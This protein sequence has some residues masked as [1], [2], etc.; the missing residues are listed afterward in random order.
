MTRI[1]VTILTGFLGSGKTTLLNR[2]LRDPQLKGSVVIVNE[3]GEI[4]LDHELIEASSDSVVLLRNGCLCC[5]VRGDLVE[6]LVDLHRKR[7]KGEISAFDHVVIETSGLAEPTPVTEVLVAAPGV[8]SCFSLA[9]I[10]ATVDA[11]NG[12]V[13]LDAHEQSVKQVALADRIV[14]TKSD[15]LTRP[16]ELRERLGRL[17]PACEVLDARDVDAGALMRF[18][19]GDRQEPAWRSV[20]ASHGERQVGGS[21]PHGEAHGHDARIRRFAIVRDEPW[22][23]DTLTLLL[24]ALATNAGPALLRVKG[25]IH[26]KD[27]PERP[28]VIHGAQELVH[29]LSW[30]DRWPSEDRRT[31]IVFI[32]MDQGAEEIGELV[33]D[34][35][36]L[37]QRTR[38]ARSRGGRQVEF[39][40]DGENR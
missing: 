28:A 40:P 21:G 18:P 37:S 34:I 1:P 38:A 3:F 7:L 4:G 22:D 23:L 10:V 33:E 2:A 27:S 35:E 36:R 13:T 6:T 14:M 19:A 39:S 11:V 30:L 24:E 29:S 25:L 5:S 16:D 17:N 15:L 31:R 20:A 32:T 9:G 26:M 12:L 8:N